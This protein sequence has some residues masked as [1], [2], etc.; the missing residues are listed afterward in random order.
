MP[1]KKTEDKADKPVKSSTKAESPKVSKVKAEKTA[2]AKAAKSPK[3]APKTAKAATKAEGS[4]V[5]KAGL[6][7]K[8][9]PKKHSPE[10]AFTQNPSPDV[11]ILPQS[12]N[13]V[14]LIWRAQPE[15]DESTDSWVIRTSFGEKARV[16]A[17]SRSAFLTG[18]GVF[19]VDIYRV[20]RD[21]SELLF[22]SKTTKKE[23]EYFSNPSSGQSEEVLPRLNS[24][25]QNF[26]RRISS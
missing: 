9:S 1:T 21:G 20:L 12:Q 5:S 7:R 14:F 23:E 17:A 15:L 13:K 3:D 19:T 16:P 25:S 10:K 11:V 4:K 8:T 18:S 22:L 2:P 6:A 26:R 24:S